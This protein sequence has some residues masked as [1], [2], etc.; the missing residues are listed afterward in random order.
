MK[1]QERQWAHTGIQEF[2]VKKKKPFHWGGE[3]RDQMGEQAAQRC[4]E[5][6][7]L[8]DIPNPSEHI[9]EQPVL[10]DTALNRGLD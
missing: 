2:A 5:V 10:G 9:P 6:F 1:G 7:I 8:G 3:G 4:C